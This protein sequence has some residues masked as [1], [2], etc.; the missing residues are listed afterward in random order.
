MSLTALLIQPRNIE[1]NDP[2]ITPSQSLQSALNVA[3][4]GGGGLPIILNAPLVF[5]ATVTEDHVLSAEIA[6]HPVE[7]GVDVTDHV[8]IK[9]RKLVLSVK[10]SDSP[11]AGGLLGSIGSIAAGLS[12][13]FGLSRTLENYQTLRTLFFSRV[14]F[15]IVTGI[16]VYENM[17]MESISIPRS[18]DSDGELRFNIVAREIYFVD[19]QDIGSEFSEIFPVG[20]LPGETALGVGGVQ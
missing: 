5:D 20:D 15:N 19:T 6:E 2:R 4:A 10:T 12:S 13:T 11:L 17:L 8:R 9:P 18:V 1:F 16:D 7:T 3:D 14:P